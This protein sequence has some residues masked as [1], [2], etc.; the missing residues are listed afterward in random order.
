MV[1]WKWLCG[2]EL[3]K[4]CADN[5]LFIGNFGL[6]FLVCQRFYYKFMVERRCE[7]GTW[8]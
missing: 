2:F 1:V 4:S 8:A 7:S 5:G 6:D 3:C